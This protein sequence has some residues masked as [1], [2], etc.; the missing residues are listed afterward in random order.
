MVAPLMEAGNGGK[1]TSECVWRL[2]RITCP[3]FRP[4]IAVN[5]NGSE[6]FFWKFRTDMNG[7]YCPPRTYIYT[8]VEIS[9]F[10]CLVVNK[11]HDM[12]IPW[13]FLV[14]IPTEQGTYFLSCCRMR[15]AH[16]NIENIIDDTPPSYVHHLASIN[17]THTADS[18]NTI[19]ICI[20]C[21]E[22]CRNP[23]VPV[24]GIQAWTSE[25]YYPFMDA[26]GTQSLTVFQYGIF[27]HWWRYVGDDARFRIVAVHAWRTYI[28]ILAVLIAIGIGF[29]CISWLS[30]FT[31]PATVLV[32]NIVAHARLYEI[33]IALHAEIVVVGRPKELIFVCTHSPYVRTVA[34]AASA[35]ALHLFKLLHRQ[36]CGYVLVFLVCQAIISL[37]NRC[38]VY[39]VNDQPVIIVYTWTHPV[40]Y[41]EHIERI[42]LLHIFE[43]FCQIIPGNTHLI[44]QLQQP[45]KR[46]L[47]AN[48]SCAI[49]AGF[50]FH[51]KLMDIHKCLTTI[52]CV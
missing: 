12:E 19:A 30:V 22:S 28:G 15:Y 14:T 40:L 41:L 31:C 17:I 18:Q 33:A 26:A 10:G 45:C 42:H 37:V 48:I 46:V 51:S 36:S 11:S 34:L 21:N 43:H 32:W 16:G 9:K 47:F 38:L 39:S 24:T 35:I 1:R 23:R 44:Q 2:C 13:I 3:H 49:A 7:R 4:H 27:I 6:T 29:L 20:V 52:N 25:E 5:T 50:F 8:V